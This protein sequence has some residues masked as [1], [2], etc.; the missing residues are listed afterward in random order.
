M[1]HI[2]GAFTQRYNRKH[3]LDGQ[4]FRG[5]YKAIVVAE[6][7]YLLQLVRYIHRNPIR[8]GMVDKAERYEWSSHEGYLSS[9]E[10][11]DSLHKQ[12]ILSM[13]TKNRQERAKRYRAFLGEAEDDTLLR[14]LSLKKL[15]SILGDNQFVDQLKGRFFEQKWHI[16][17]PESKRLAPDIALIKGAICKHYGIE[18]ASAIPNKKGCL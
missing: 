12:F 10:K 1:R 14:I 16:E 13:L 5:K 11:W 9:A 4:L 15:P 2:N 8:A 6:E 7:S 17:V 3:S 18:E